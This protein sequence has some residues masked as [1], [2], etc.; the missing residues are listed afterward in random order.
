VAFNRFGGPEVLGVADLPVP[1]PR[2]GEIRVKVAAATVNPTD[3]GMRAG[4]QAATL[5]SIDPPYVPGMEL[6]GVVDRVGAGSN[7]QIGDRVLGITLPMRT[8][9]G[10]QAEHVIVPSDSVVRIPSGVTFEDAATLPM[11]GLTAQRALD[12]LGLRAGQTLAV[13]GAAGAVGGYAVQ[14]GAESGLRVIGVA[15]PADEALVRGFGAWEFVPRGAEMANSIRGI[16]PD[17]VD[18]LVDAAAIGRAV[19]EAIRDDGK[20]AVVRG[21]EGELERGISVDHVRVSDYARN[22]SALQCLAD[23]VGQGKL[24][25]RV[26]ETFEP[27]RAAEAHARLHEGGIRGRLVILF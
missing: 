9:R 14:L 8:G 25:L 16:V 2:Q 22:Q 3:L 6:A 7:W 20:L 5:S 10:A 15:S 18:G 11:N 26:A 4:R 24:S 27:E 23:L 19:L 12:V 1:E 13:T 21:F 17:G